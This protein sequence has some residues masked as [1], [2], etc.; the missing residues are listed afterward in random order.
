MIQLKPTDL[1]LLAHLGHHSRDSYAD[2]AKTLHISREQVAYRIEKFLKEDLI[3][4][5]FPIVNYAALSY[6]LITMLFLAFDKRQHLKT[7]KKT[8]AHDKNRISHGEILAKYDIFII[9]A[10]KD[11]SEKKNYLSSLLSHK[12]IT[13]HLILEPHHIQLYPLKFMGKREQSPF[14][15]ID[16]TLSMPQKIDEK[17]RKI[18]KALTK[19]AR[20]KVIDIAKQTNIS[21][22]LIVYHLKQLKTKNIL[23]GSRAYFN[24]EKLGF[25][26]TLLFL[27]LKRLSTS[28]QQT[29]KQF[30]LQ[31]PHIETVSFM[32]TKPNCYLQVFHKDENQLR[33]TIL[34]LKELLRDEHYELEI[35]PIKDAGEDI[36]VMPFL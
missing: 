1:K 7:F 29:L 19:D 14:L 3:K 22:E 9:L 21:A 25:F 6:P 26:Y 2:I 12:T 4:G 30:A 36:N 5:F 23:L 15:M 27:N 13:D 34:S 8:L 10:F 32:F 24:M 18:L 16:N 20:M 33:Q 17:D 28:T 35:L 11:E 31:D